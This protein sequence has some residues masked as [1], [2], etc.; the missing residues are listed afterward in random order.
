[1]VSK[2]FSAQ[3]LHSSAYYTDVGPHMSPSR[4]SI[5]PPD[6]LSQ[7][8]YQDHGKLWRRGARMP[9]GHSGM[10]GMLPHKHC[11]RSLHTR[12]VNYP[13]Y[14]Q[15]FEERLVNTRPRYHADRSSACLP[16]WLESPRRVVIAH[17][18]GWESANR[19]VSTIWRHPYSTVDLTRCAVLGL[20][21]GKVT[22]TCWSASCAPNSG[23]L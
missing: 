13:L 6:T 18:E 2:N 20:S 12:M 9:N 11:Q 10:P 8:P 7:V 19:S 16:L 22:K 3:E 5:H 17:P 21:C 4:H 1:V 15:S 14:G 23:E